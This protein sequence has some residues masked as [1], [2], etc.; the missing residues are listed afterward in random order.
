MYLC[1]FHGA[2][3][4]TLAHRFLLRVAAYYKEKQKA[5]N[6]IP[7]L[8][9]LEVDGLFTVQLTEWEQPSLD[10]QQAA[11]EFEIDLREYIDNNRLKSSLY[12]QTKKLMVRNCNIINACSDNADSL[13]C[14]HYLFQD[15]I[16]AERN[17]FQDVILAAAY[18]VITFFFMQ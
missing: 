16:S 3:K 13:M 15:C 7:E 8:L 6:F 12:S 17:S 18:K 1:R 9:Q 11:T 5:T 10:D 4:Q 14:V 2:T